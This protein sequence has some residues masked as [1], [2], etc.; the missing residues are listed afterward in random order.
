MGG[1][2]G[3]FFNFPVTM[4]PW[5][6]QVLGDTLSKSPHI[7]GPE[8]NVLYRLMHLMFLR[9][10]LRESLESMRMISSLGRSSKQ[11][12]V[13]NQVTQRSTIV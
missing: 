12:M 11:R 3:N 13:R 10:M 6:T 5:K 7:S 9:F 2:I 1:D 8:K 4:K